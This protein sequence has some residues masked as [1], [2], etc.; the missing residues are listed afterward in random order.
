MP[1]AAASPKS[2]RNR[3]SR[4]KPSCDSCYF[5][6]RMLCALELGEPCSTFR[7]DSPHGLVPPAQPML[8][9]GADEAV[10]EPELLAA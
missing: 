3:R 10:L 1:N 8:L 6:V 2:R 7:P 5:G 9:I 4:Q